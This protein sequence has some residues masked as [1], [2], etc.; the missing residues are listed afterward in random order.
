MKLPF[1]KYGL[2][3]VVIYPLAV[4]IMM[5][6]A[7]LMRRLVRPDW[8]YLVVEAILL[9]VL[10]WCLSFFRDPNRPIVKD[11]SLLLSPADG[12][13]S[14]VEILKTSEHFNQPVVRIGIFL[15]IFNVHINRIPCNAK[16]EKITYRPGKF[17]NALNPKSSRVNESNDIFMNRMNQPT[18]KMLVRQISGAIAKRIVCDA[19]PGDEFDGGK[20]FGMIKFGSRTELWIPERE[21][22]KTLVRKGDKVKAGLTI[23]A[24]YENE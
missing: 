17:K 20:I 12:T 13:V 8:S 16:I 3:E 1:T 2:P 14:D 6:I 9:I 18:D 5:I 11:P 19:A 4:V 15:S 22:L 24:K 23:L 10:I 21:N 7:F